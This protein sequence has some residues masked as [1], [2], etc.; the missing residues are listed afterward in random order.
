MKRSAPKPKSAAKLRKELDAVF[1][2]YVRLKFADANG[3]AR[4]YT[5]GAYK[6]WKELQN[7]HFIRRQYL[8]TRF[9][10]RNCRPQCVGCNMFGDGKTV[11]FSARL[12]SEN[13]GMTALLYREAQK[14]VKNFPYEEKIAEYE[15]KLGKLGGDIHI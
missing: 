6:H 7:G 8:A 11:E 13:P 9:D 1:S 2:R 14:I 3:N 10:E 12:E 5:C 15:A 4:C